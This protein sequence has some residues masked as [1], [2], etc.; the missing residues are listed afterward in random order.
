M[1]GQAAE[2]RPP[3]VRNGGIGHFH[4]P[5][6]VPPT[7]AMSLHRRELALGA[8]IGSHVFTS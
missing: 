6:G 8:N 5:S 1:M 4:R 3:Q 2:V 7:A